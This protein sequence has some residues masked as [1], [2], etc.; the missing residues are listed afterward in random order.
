MKRWLVVIGLFVSI[1]IITVMISRMDWETFVSAFSQIKYYW[2]I[3]AA[4]FV[5]V[6]QAVRAL[7]WNFVSGRPVQ[8]YS[9]FW[10]SAVLGQLCNF[11][12]PLRA[13]DILRMMSLRKFAKVPLGQAVTSAVVDRIN[14]GFLLIVLLLFVLSRHGIEVIGITAVSSILGSFGFMILGVILFVVWGQHCTVFVDKLSYRFS[15]TMGTKIRQSY[16]SILEVSG[17]FRQPRRLLGMVVVNVFVVTCDLGLTATLILTMGWD[18]PLAAALTIAVFLWAGSALPSAPGFLGIYQIACVLALKLYGVDESSA[19]AY[20][21]VLHILSFAA[22]V[23]Q[24]SLA[25]TSYGINLR[26]EYA[27]GLVEEQSITVDK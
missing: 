9:H 4:T 22:V 6:G 19:L 21:V 12:Y 27:E 2:L 7:R 25:I 10:R 5:F 3:V 18:L 1:A 15:M 17:A 23:A 24:G 13:G 8:Q 14:D 26:R 20:S 16:K 11:I